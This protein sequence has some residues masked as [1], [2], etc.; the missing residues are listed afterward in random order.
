M[1]DDADSVAVKTYVPPYQKERWREHAE[2]LGMSQSEFV[3]TMVQAG[4]RDFEVPGPT[5]DEDAG[6]P[7]SSGLEPQVRDALDPKDGRSWD[8]LVAAVT[9]D[10]EDRLE[11]TLAELQRRNVVQHSPRAGGYRL[12]E[13]A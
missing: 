12:V 11:E 3:R 8:D 5:E 7:P 6:E 9:E 4:R 1:G 2:R 10:V 13:D